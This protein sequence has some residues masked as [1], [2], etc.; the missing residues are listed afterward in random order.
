MGVNPMKPHELKTEVS[1]EYWCS[2]IR[3]MEFD[4]TGK[5]K[6]HTGHDY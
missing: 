3:G 6:I 5:T 4:N 1:Q 2:A